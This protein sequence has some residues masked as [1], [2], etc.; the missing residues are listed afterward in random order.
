M[1][2]AVAN[3]FKRKIRLTFDSEVTEIY[4]PM[5]YR[6]IQYYVSPIIENVESVDASLF[7]PFALYALSKV[8]HEGHNIPID[9]IEINV[10]INDLQEYEDYKLAFYQFENPLASPELFFTHAEVYTRPFPSNLLNQPFRVN[11]NVTCYYICSSRRQEVRF[12]RAFNYYAYW[13]YN[14]PIEY[15]SDEEI[16][17]YENRDEESSDN[18]STD[19]EEDPPAPLIETYRQDCCVVCLESKPNILYFD[20]MHIAVCDSCDLLKRTAR[21]RKNCDVCRAKISR[22]IKI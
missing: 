16:P 11:A 20:C 13:R 12:R 5:A 14:L 3:L 1:D 4:E 15:C 2:M 9:Y 22:R 18:E 10:D 7:K 19:E 6:R 17:E 21:A 8:I